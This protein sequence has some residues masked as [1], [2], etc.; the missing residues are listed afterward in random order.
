MFQGK[1]KKDIVLNEDVLRGGVMI[2]TWRLDRDTLVSNLTLYRARPADKVVSLA[3]SVS[4]LAQGLYSC[5]LP[6]GLS[7]LGRHTVRLHIGDAELP[8]AVHSDGKTSPIVW[9]CAD[10]LSK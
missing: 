6:G 9:C 7:V 10:V 4:H 2:N 8:V 1:E 5:S 3:C